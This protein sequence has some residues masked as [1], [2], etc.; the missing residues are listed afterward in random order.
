MLQEIIGNRIKK[1]RILKNLTQQELAIKAKINRSYLTSV[2]NGTRNI[3][4][5]NLEKIILALEV[6]Y[7]Y[8]FR[9]EN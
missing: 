3:T 6:D 8:F 5:Y 9:L 2:E 7:E 4:I 1:I